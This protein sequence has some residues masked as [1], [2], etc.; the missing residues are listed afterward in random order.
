[1]RTRVNTAR[2]NKPMPYVIPDADFNSKLK[3]PEK[4]IDFTKLFLTS[5]VEDFTLPGY[6]TPH[7]YRLVKSLRN[8]QYRLIAEGDEPETVYLVELRFRNDVVYG[9]QTCTQIKVWR[10]ISSIHNAAVRELPRTFF[11]NLLKEYSIV[12][13]DEEQTADGKRFWETMIDWSL[14]TGYFVYISDGTQE[15][16]PL[17]PVHSMSDFYNKWEKFCWGEDRDVHTH[18]LTVITKGAL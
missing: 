6:V 14:N 15:D 9:K 5:G 13:S 2:T 12:V 1:M 16:R 10:T 17:S 18:R 11:S 7:G 3:A 8:N 4:N